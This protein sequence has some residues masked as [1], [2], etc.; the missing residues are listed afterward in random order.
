MLLGYNHQKAK[1]QYPN[2][3]P[4]VKLEGKLECKN[5]I[6]NLMTLNDWAS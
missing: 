4:I 1:R 2:N 6:R 5:L 3:S